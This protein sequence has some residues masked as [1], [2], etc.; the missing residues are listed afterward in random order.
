MTN[1]ASTEEK[2]VTDKVVTDADLSDAWDQ[3]EKAEEKVVETTVEPE[4]VVKSIEEEPEEP[5]DHGERSRMGRRVARMEQQ[6]EQIISKLDSINYPQ[7]R[8]TIRSRETTIENNEEIPEIVSTPQ[9]VERV[10]NARD[11]KIQEEQTKYEGEYISTL[12]KLRPK[13][14]DVK[15]E[16][17]LHE[18]TLS[19][20]EKEW[21]VFG[22]RHS[23]YPNM[24]AELNY[25]KA[26]A[27]ILSKKM[28]SPKP[29]RPN[30]KGERPVVSTSLSV[31]SGGES[32]ASVGLPPLDDFAADFVKRTGMKEESV[33]EA[34]KGDT[35]INLAKVK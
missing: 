5:T 20:M 7:D 28:A 23:N 2:A 19:L 4:K 14:M 27:A 3:E 26:K 33:R 29:I 21:K 11:R 1:G 12:N 16:A 22:L 15:E 8:G 6:F 31:G 32:H 24:D 18:E 25:S 17:E 10:I 35:P 13:D 9:D 34:L 30:V